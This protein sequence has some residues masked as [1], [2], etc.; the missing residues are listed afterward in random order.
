MFKKN[1]SSPTLEGR[2]ELT[3]QFTWYAGCKFVCLRVRNDLLTIPYHNMSV[4][5]ADTCL[6]RLKVKINGRVLFQ[7]LEGWVSDTSPFYLLCCRD[8]ER[9]RI[10]SKAL[11][12]KRR[13]Y[14]I[15]RAQGVPSIF[16]VPKKLHTS[17]RVS[18]V[19]DHRDAPETAFS[20]SQHYQYLFSA[21]L[22][23]MYTN[24]EQSTHAMSIR[25]LCTWFSG[26]IT[27]TFQ[28]EKPFKQKKP[29]H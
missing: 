22:E 7:N 13:K 17:D 16:P 25:S 15:L 3:N 4:F 26:V 28:R 5:L 8:T 6:I 9:Y 10:Q 14:S 11:W 23:E 29:N 27:T 1:E 18:V 24:Q 20:A 2:P 21:Y 19:F 12:I